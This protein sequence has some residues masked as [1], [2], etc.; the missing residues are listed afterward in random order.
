MTYKKCFWKD[1]FLPG[2]SLIPVESRRE[3]V[4]SDVKKIKQ[5]NVKK[6]LQ[7]VK[8]ERGAALLQTRSNDPSP[9]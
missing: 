5:G 1:S 7:T 9:R 6:W 8:E 4:H 3:A 2:D